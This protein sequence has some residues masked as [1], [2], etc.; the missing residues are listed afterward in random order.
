MK[1]AVFLDGRTVE[2]KE[3]PEPTPKIGEVKIRVKSA[4]ICGSDL[5]G[6]RSGKLWFPEAA[7]VILGH[8]LAGEVVSVGKLVKNIREGDR[9][10]VQP[11]IT[12]GKCY[13]CLKG[14]FQLC[15][16]VKHIGIWYNGGF[17][18]YVTVPEKNAYKI[19][20][21]LDFNVASLADVYGCGVHCYNRVGKGFNEYVVVIGTGPIALST[22][23]IFKLRSNSKIIVIGRREEVL[24][25]A[26]E[27]ADADEIIN[28]SK[29]EAVKE[30]NKLTSGKGADVVIEAVGGQADTLDIA[31][32]I[33]AL[34]GIIGIMGEFFNKG[35]VPLQTGMEKQIDLLW[36]TGYGN[37]EGESEFQ[38]AIDL[39]SSKQLKAN[40]IIT[41]CFPL[42]K[43][44]EAFEVSNSKAK[45]NSIKV[46]ITPIDDPVKKYPPEKL[47]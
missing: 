37:W 4:G 3:V 35:L 8:E 9:V 5:H 40:E 10:T 28:I 17:A 11:Q 47:S 43:I 20:D 39:L 24:K 26:L 32:N 21:N 38:S 19:L 42:E 31:F 7:P 12:C 30:I 18:E 44:K 36:S 41:H 34:D 45:Y 13:A 2:I 1:A 46:I 15:P 27:I 14:T 6:W 29:Q 25:K 33:V 23:Q 16:S 22:A